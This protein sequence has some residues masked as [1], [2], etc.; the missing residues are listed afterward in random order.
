MLNFL[1]NNDKIF[2]KMTESVL[3]GEYY[4]TVLYC[5]KPSNH[6][7]DLYVVVFKDESGRPRSLWC[8]AT[9][10]KEKNKHLWKLIQSKVIFKVSRY[11]HEC[12]VKIEDM[13]F[14]GKLF[15]YPQDYEKSFLKRAVK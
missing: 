14:S 12:P 10:I 1:R 7:Y 9:V 5:E 13:V 15:Y 11:W 6:Y 4:G 3:K 2:F 8:P